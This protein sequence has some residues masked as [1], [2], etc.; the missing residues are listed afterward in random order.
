MVANED[1]LRMNPKASVHN[2]S[3]SIFDHYMLVLVLNRSQPRKPVKKP[4]AMWTREEGCRDVVES[5]WDPL[6]CD[7]GLIITDKLKW[8]QEQL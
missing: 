2:F 8:C 1:W 7:S 5:A 4:E 3:M 6:R